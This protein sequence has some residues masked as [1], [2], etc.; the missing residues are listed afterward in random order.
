MQNYG[1]Y[2]GYALKI[3]DHELKEYKMVDNP[4]LLGC[5]D[6]NGVYV[7][8][9]DCKKWMKF[10]IDKWECPKCKGK[11]LKEVAYEYIEELNEEGEE[12]FNED[13]DDYY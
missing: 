13:Y 3:E 8:C 4:H 12:W 1:E 2:Y 10:H 7:Y 11:L 5:D 9:A 6:G